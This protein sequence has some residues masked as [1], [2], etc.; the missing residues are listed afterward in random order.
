[1]A[2]NRQDR[3]AGLLVSQRDVRDHAGIGAALGVHHI[4]GMVPLLAGGIPA[5]QEVIVPPDAGAN[6][7][8]TLRRGPGGLIRSRE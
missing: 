8:V 5:A 4:H 1:M 3:M 6:V 2:S 7:T